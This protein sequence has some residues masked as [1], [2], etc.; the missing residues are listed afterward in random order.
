[1]ATRSGSRIEAAKSTGKVAGGQPPLLYVLLY[2][3]QAVARRTT[4]WTRSKAPV[5]VLAS[6]P[7]FQLY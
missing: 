3:M 2:L 1:M 6:R 5:A 4:N 7:S